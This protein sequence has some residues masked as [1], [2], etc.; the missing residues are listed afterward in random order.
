MEGPKYGSRS[1][2]T[3]RKEET[4]SAIM[5]FKLLQSSFDVRIVEMFSFGS[6]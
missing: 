2:E 4:W 3:E 1:Q 5:F 6:K